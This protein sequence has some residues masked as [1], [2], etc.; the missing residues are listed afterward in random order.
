M[1]DKFEKFT[2][3]SDYRYTKRSKV[4]IIERLGNCSMLVSDIAITDDG[5]EF[6]LKDTYVVK[7]S[8]LYLERFITWEENHYNQVKIDCDK[9]AES[10]LKDRADAY[11]L[12]KERQNGLA[13]QIKRIDGFKSSSGERHLANIVNMLTGIATH[14]IVYNRIV[15]VEKVLWNDSCFRVFAT[16]EGSK[17]DGYLFSKYDNSYSNS[18]LLFNSR[19]DAVSHAQDKLNDICARHKDNQDIAVNTISDIRTLT[20]NMGVKSPEAMRIL[21][22]HDLR[23]LRSEEEKFQVGLKEVQRKIITAKES[24]QFINDLESP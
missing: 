19:D 12:H 8:D 15:P 6:A 9:L 5:K 23:L 11:K 20:L 13:Q 22:E 10:M 2:I 18:T 7:E 1:T 3:D 14:A 17:K 21:E 24:Y 16:E 4:K